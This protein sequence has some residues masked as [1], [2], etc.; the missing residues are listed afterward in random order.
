[1][2]KQ[3]G[4]SKHLSTSK[5]SNKRKQNWYFEL[6]LFAILSFS[7]DVLAALTDMYIYMYI[8]YIHL[9]TKEWIYDLRLGMAEDR[10][11]SSIKALGSIALT[12]CTNEI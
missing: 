5:Y 8:G 12:I 3:Y 7:N 9:C 11:H 1:M 10:P 6:D 4:Y 2:N